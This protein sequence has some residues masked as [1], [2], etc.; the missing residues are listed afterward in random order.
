MKNG[1]VRKVTN[2]GLMGN[3]RDNSNHVVVETVSIVG[4]RSVP[5]SRAHCEGGEGLLERILGISVNREVRV[6]ADPS[7]SVVVRDIG[8]VVAR[9]VN[10]HL[11]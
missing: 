9:L 8:S 5:E 10:D 7:G 3:I 1:R 2:R 4:V 11:I 6:V